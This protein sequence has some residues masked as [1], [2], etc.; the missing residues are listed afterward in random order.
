MRE[1]MITLIERLIHWGD[2]FCLRTFAFLYIKSKISNYCNECYNLVVSIFCKYISRK[3]VIRL[4]QGHKLIVFL[5]QTKSLI[6]KIYFSGFFLL[7]WGLV[8]YRC[9]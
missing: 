8:E 6:Y 3:P 7:V 4:R 1:S 2:S 5:K 9:R